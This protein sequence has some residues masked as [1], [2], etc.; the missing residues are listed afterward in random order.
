[1]AWREDM[2]RED[3]GTQYE[4][5]TADAL[6]P[7]EE[8]ELVRVLAAAR[9]L[10]THDSK[11]ITEGRQTGSAVVLVSTRMKPSRPEPTT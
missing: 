5:M 4:R 7:P 10:R 6:Q 1:M 11:Q 2:R 9:R 3:N 8:P